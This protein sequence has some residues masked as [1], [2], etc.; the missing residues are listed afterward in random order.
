MQQMQGKPSSPRAR[1]VGN[2][3]R[4]CVPIKVPPEIDT[5]V[6]AGNV[7]EVGMNFCATNIMR[8]RVKENKA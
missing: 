6:I 2:I 7:V 3:E 4:M 5:G 8:S 1:S